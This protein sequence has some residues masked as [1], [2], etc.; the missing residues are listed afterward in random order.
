MV[1]PISGKE[2]PLA[3]PGSHAALS[4]SLLPANRSIQPYLSLHLFGCIFQQGDI[5][6]D[7]TVPHSSNAHDEPGFLPEQHLTQVKLSLTMLAL[8]EAPIVS[9]GRIHQ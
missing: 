7:Y 2:K 9:W 6:C 1:P 3:N 4:H 8:H 5:P